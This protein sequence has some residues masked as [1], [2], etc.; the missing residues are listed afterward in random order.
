MERLSLYMSTHPRQGVTLCLLAGLLMPLAFAPWSLFPLALLL[1]AT[2]FAC[3]LRAAPARAFVYGWSFGMGMFVHG[4]YWVYHSMHV[5]GHMPLPLAMALTLLLAGYF[6]LFPALLGWLA[7]HYWPLSEPLRLLL[8]YPV[9]WTLLEWVRGWFL[10]GFP[11]LNLGYSQT[12]SWLAG[13][14]PWVGVYGISWVVALSAGLLVLLFS[15]LPRLRVGALVAL[16]ALWLTGAAAG[17]VEWSEPAGA[18]VTVSLVQGNITQSTKW[19]PRQQRQI[20]N[21]YMEQTQQH[22]DSDL[23]IWPETAVP[24]FYQSVERD[25]VQALERKARATKTDLLIGLPMFAGDGEHYYNSMVSIGSERGFYRKRHLV[26]FGEFVPLRDWLQDM[27]DV[28]RVPMAAFSAGEMQ[29]APL[30]VAGYDAAISICYEIAFGEEVIMSLPQANF[31]VNVSNN[32]WFGDSSAPHQQ[33]QMARMRAQESGRYVVSATNDG[34]TAIVDHRG[35]VVQ[36]APQFQALVLSGTV[37]PRKGA[38][39][40]VRSGNYPVIIAL[41]LLLGGMIYLVRKGK[42]V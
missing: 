4:V 20:I 40:Y 18:P 42:A 9:L 36:V 25:F 3:W 14:A 10:S 34:M 5:F 12:D 29:Q 13:L 1:P 16:A 19:Q 11:W 26:P 32:A 24:A 8:V 38:T 31:L 2:L 37:E 27:L 21:S 30:R 35:R 22:W 23:I 17:W 33:L 15:G 7:N 6:A 28:L 41:W 39:P